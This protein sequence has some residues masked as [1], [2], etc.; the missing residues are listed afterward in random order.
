MITS[1]EAFFVGVGLFE[2]LFFGK[3]QFEAKVDRMDTLAKKSNL[4]PGSGIYSGIFI[5]YLRCPSNK[6]RTTKILF[7]AICLLYVLSAVTLA[8]DVVGLILEVSNDSICKN[9]AF[10]SVCS[11]VL[12]DYQLNFK[13]PQRACYFALKLPK[14]QQTLFVTSS[15]NVS[16]Y[17]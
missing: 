1:S 3:I 4:F 7:Y 15:A 16:W 6:S 2:G 10:L 8:C 12:G 9:R 13:L 5:M 11:R 14:A 17:A